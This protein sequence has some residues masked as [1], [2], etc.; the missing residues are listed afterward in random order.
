[1]HKALVRNCLKKMTR[2]LLDRALSSC[3]MISRLVLEKRL[4]FY[5][6]TAIVVRGSPVVVVSPCE[7]NTL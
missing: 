4:C 2:G 1:M 7:A 6:I 3:I 5:F